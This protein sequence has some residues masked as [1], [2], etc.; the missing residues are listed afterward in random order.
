MMRTGKGLL[1]HQRAAGWCKAVG[2]IP[3]YPLGAVH[4]TK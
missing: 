1:P 3:L 4:R 2:G